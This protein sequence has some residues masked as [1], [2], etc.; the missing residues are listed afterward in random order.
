VSDTDLTADRVASITTD[1]RWDRRDQP[2][3]PAPAEV[4]KLLPANY[5]LG[6]A[7]SWQI[8]VR[9]KDAGD[10]TLE[11][12]IAKL[13]GAGM[14][15]AEVQ[16]EGIEA[17]YQFRTGKDGGSGSFLSPPG[18]PSLAYSIYGYHSS[19]KGRPNTNRAS[20][21]DLIMGIDG[22][23]EDE[24]GYYP[25][26]A[27]EKAKRLLAEATTEPSE[28]WIRH[29][30]GYFAHSY[31]PD[32]VDRN[33]SNAL[34]SSKLH[35]ACGET[36]Y[37]QRGLNHHIDTAR[38][39]MRGPKGG[40]IRGSGGH[41][42]VPSPTF[43][44]EHHLAYLMIKSYFPN[45]TPRLDLIAHPEGLYGTRE[46]SKCHE[47]C[48]YEARWDKWAVFGKG[49][50]CP[51]GGDHEM[52]VPEGEAARIRFQANCHA[53]EG[54]LHAT[55]CSEDGCGCRHYHWSGAASSTC[56]CTHGAT[57][58]HN[59]RNN[60]DGTFDPETE[61]KLAAA[62]AAEA[63]DEP[64]DWAGRTFG[65]LTDDEKRRAA[66]QAGRQL[67][68]EMTQPAFVEALGKVMEMEDDCCEDC[69]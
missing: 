43:P 59:W 21:P 65:E 8:L 32:G 5:R 36:S 54:E 53:R 15:A 22:L 38:A 57:G 56:T 46:C 37:N 11:A 61:A 14:K 42:Q 68:D 12:V 39:R 19:G 62:K 31:S 4:A 26:W 10:D 64:V 51:Q 17:V 2:T 7:H 24:G 55:F 27:V 40:K 50:D 1:Y 23:A 67:E 34:S 45:A 66:K 48:Q 13:T 69:K 49:P 18:H 35:C 58:S 20:G 9:G 52:A 41:Y 63:D 28:E 25:K 3:S 16:R 47:R 60:C 29:A 30:Y 33:V 44:P 6:N